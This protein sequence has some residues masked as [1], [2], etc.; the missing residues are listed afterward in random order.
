MQGPEKG[1]RFELPDAP[2]LIGRDSKKVPLRDDTASRRHCEITPGS[3][4]WQCR[5]LGSSNGTYVNGQRILHPTPLRLGDQV[6]I[7]RSVLIF[8]SQPGIK[9]IKTTKSTST[10]AT[11]SWELPFVDDIDGMDS[12]IV[13]VVPA[14]GDD[15]MILDSPDPSAAAMK[16]LSTLY[17]LSAALGGSFSIERALETVMDLVFEN[18]TADRGIIL[19]MNERTGELESKVA[20]TREDDS[21]A[22]LGVGGDAPENEPEHVPASK[23]I[24]NHVLENN[25]GVL[26]SNAMADRRFSKGKSVQHMRIRSALCVPIR[27]KRFDTRPKD[28][29]AD[30]TDLEPEEHTLGVIYV[31]SSVENYTYGEEQLKLL[32]AIGWQAGLAI[33]NAKLFQQGLQAERLAA[34]GE[35][36]AAL[37]HGIKNILQALRGGA[38][39]VEMGFRREDLKQSRKGWRIVDR[40]LERIFSLT[41]NL[42]AWSKPRQPKLELA[43]PR[44]LIH[45]CTELIAPLARDRSV[46]VIEDVDEGV[47]PVPVDGGGIHQI[48]TNLLTN[49]LEAMP[50]KDDPDH[51][52][53]DRIVKVGCQYEADLKR[54]ILTVADT[55]LGIPRNARKHLFEL[56]HSTKGNRGTGLGLP[57]VKKIVAEH[58]GKIDVDTK[59]GQGTIFTITLPVHERVANDPAG[60]HGR[61]S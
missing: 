58:D 2:I 51:A 35:T 29:G 39:V 44:K 36:T 32:T 30:L 42:L 4:G 28:G 17:R 26:S 52:E 21:A 5:D 40:N 56:F 46:M 1:K 18:V 37:S 19:L 47:P 11:G 50:D 25:Q 3:D 22:V 9:S 43:H 38:E 33:Q 49:A 60:T 10:S 15:S 41:M 59:V 31:D 53:R 20:R 14:S 23:T 16:N 24:V 48:L 7:G 6:R 55:G 61:I 8:G 13:N 12:S 57:V 45:E 27:A 54:L 34:I